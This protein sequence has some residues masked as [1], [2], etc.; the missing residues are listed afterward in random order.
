MNL[1]KNLQM[2]WFVLKKQRKPNDFPSFKTPR[3]NHLLQVILQNFIRFSEYARLWNGHKCCSNDIFTTRNIQHAEKPARLFESS[4]YLFCFARWEQQVW[5]D[6][7]VSESFFDVLPCLWDSL[8]FDYCILPNK[9][10]AFHQSTSPTMAGKITRNT[11]WQFF[12]K[13]Y[14]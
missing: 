1:S 4:T 7:I 13:T 11:T 9:Y 12:W 2:F 6:I 14:G 3:K 8:S 10:A 5:L